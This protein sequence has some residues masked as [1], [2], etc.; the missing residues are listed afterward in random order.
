MTEYDFDRTAR[1]WL[2]DGPSQM[3]D[4]AL[5]AALAT[6]H[7]T[8]QRRAFWPAWLTTDMTIPIRLAAGLAVVL[9][10]IV[11]LTFLPGTRIGAP[12]PSPTAT[13]SPSPQA[14]PDIEEPLDAGRWAASSPFPVP[15]T[16][17]IPAGW[18]GNVGGPYAVFLTPGSAW[19][20]LSITSFST[21]FADPCHSEQGAMRPA[22]GRA[23]DDLITALRNVPSLTVSPVTDI[24][25]SG[26]PAKE[27]TITAPASFAGCNLAEAGLYRLWELPLSAT[28]DLSAGERQLLRIVEV[29]GTR[30]VIDMSE[31]TKQTPAQKAEVQAVMDSIQIA[32]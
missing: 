7:R 4:R 26:H 16:F 6:V 21:V 8:R 24:T 17:T 19:G 31:P 27:L 14:L 3:P 10:A 15:I 30:Y 11:G 25:V 28:N 20:N 12:E 32:P 13:P 9:I 23:T 5:D 1:L 2:D 18:T 22:P 29:N